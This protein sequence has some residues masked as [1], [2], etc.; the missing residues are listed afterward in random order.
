MS[1]HKEVVWLINIHQPLIPQLYRALRNGLIS[2]RIVY[3]HCDHCA[4][5]TNAYTMHQGQLTMLDRKHID[6]RAIYISH[7]M[8]CS[9]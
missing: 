4:K 7:C 1:N 5:D 6:A 9:Q 2:Y 8:E 3:L